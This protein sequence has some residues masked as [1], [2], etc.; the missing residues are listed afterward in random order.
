MANAELRAVQRGG[1]AGG[2]SLPLESNELHEL[3]FAQGL[4]SFAEMT[5]KGGGWSV[6]TATLF[7]PLV[8]IP[9][10]TAALEIYNNM[11]S[12]SLLVDT[13]FASQVLSTAASQTYAIYACVST[14]KDKPTNTPLSLFSSSGRPVIVTT[15]AGRIITG[16]GTTV[17]AN[18][19]RPWGEAQ[20]WGTATAT[21]G[22][23]WHVPIDGRLLV[24]PGCA[25]LLHI[26]GALATASTFQVGASWYEADVAYVV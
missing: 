12:T 20:A 1:A 26:M 24:P 5:R 2:L 13:L 11:S 22:N 3:L 16:I 23:S 6:Q 21:P 14:K 7:A 19:W 4:P 17:V 9:T 15:A 10:T 18:G 25:L 8:A